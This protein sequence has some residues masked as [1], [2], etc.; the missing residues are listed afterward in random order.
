MIATIDNSVDTP[1]IE[2]MV[3]GNDSDGSVGGIGDLG[4]LSSH[5]GLRTASLAAS[6][7]VF[8]SKEVVVC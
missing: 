8:F 2:R 6:G 1:S 7:A 4:C 3:M 5:R